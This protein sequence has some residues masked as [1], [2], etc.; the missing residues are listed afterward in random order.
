V[1]DSRFFALLLCALF[2]LPLQADETPDFFSG[3]VPV[4][5]RSQVS[6]RQGANDALL[7]VLVRASVQSADALKRNPKLKQDLQ[8]A[9]RYTAAFSYESVPDA[10]IPLAIKVTF[11]DKVIAGILAR[12]GLTY[13][14]ANRP[15]ILLLPIMDAA[16]GPRLATAEEAQFTQAL[17]KVAVQYGLPVQLADAIEEPEA[18]LPVNQDYVYRLLQQHQK[19][20]AVVIAITRNGEQVSTQWTLQREEMTATKSIAAADVNSASEQGLWWLANELAAEY[21]VSL[22]GDGQSV[23]L[24][25]DRVDSYADYEQLI[26]YMKQVSIVNAVLI[27][28]VHK[29]RVTLKLDLKAAL[30]ELEK[31]FLLQRKIQVT[32]DEQGQAQYLWGM[33]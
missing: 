11:P 20:V 8:N 15:G 33:E 31:V 12:A 9:E 7:Q 4:N 22:V 16:G 1:V 28:S 17:T 18:L 14:E 3:I 13:W 27:K 25:I 10:P 5:N 29:E 24:I 6:F 2:T 32:R 30:P 23:D 19:P 26:A 21:K